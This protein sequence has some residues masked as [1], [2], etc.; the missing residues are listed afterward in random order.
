MRVPYQLKTRRAIDLHSRQFPQSR[1][2]ALVL[3]LS[4]LVLVTFLVMAVFQLVRTD[5]AASASYERGVSTRILSETALNLVIGQ[6]Q[7]ASQRQNEAWVSQPGLIR[8][9]DST[10]QPSRA[11]KL[12]SAARMTVSGEFDPADGGD[13][14]A[15]PS[16]WQG[17]PNEWTDMNE[18]V[19]TTQT[20]S[21]GTLV[22][23]FVYPIVDPRAYNPSSPSDSLVEGFS[24]DTA[25]TS[26][27]DASES[28]AMPVRW[29]YQLQD[30]TLTPGEP[31]GSGGA[32]RIKGMT[33]QNPAIARLAF[34]T[35]DESCKVNI[36]TAGGGVPW[37]TPA[38]ATF[39]IGAS[40]AISDLSTRPASWGENLYEADFAHFQPS[41]DEFQ[42]YP[43]HPATTSLMPILFRPI[44]LALG[45]DPNSA[46]FDQ[47]GTVR[48]AIYQMSPRIQ[49]GS[50]SSLGGTRRGSAPL[51]LA[52]DRLYASLDEFLLSENL[53]A[54]GRR[55]EHTNLGSDGNARRDLV[56]RMRFFLSPFSR[57]PETTLSNKPR[58]VAWPV[59]EN[60]SHDY[61]SSFDRLIAFCGTVGS[62]RYFFT[63][64][65]ALS[66]TDDW[67][68]RNQQIYTYLQGLTGRPIPG[69]GG[70]FLT[71]WDVDR[72]QVLTQIFDY[73]RT[74]N[75]QEFSAVPSWRPYADY[76]Q[77]HPAQRDAI[78][79]VVLPIRP[80]AGPG[81][82][83]TGFGRAHTIT[84]VALILVR[85]NQTNQPGQFRLAIVPEAFSPMAGWSAMA[86]NLRL[87]F[88]N[89][90]TFVINGV[91]VPFTNST[92][93]TFA[94]HVPASAAAPPDEYGPQ[95]GHS[96]LGGYTGPGP[97]FT[98]FTLSSVP[99]SGVFTLPTV[100]SGTNTVTFGSGGQIT[101]DVYSPAQSI[102]GASPQLLQTFDYTLPEVTLPAPRF[103]GTDPA[104]VNKQWDLRR[105]AAVGA[106]PNGLVRGMKDTEASDTV[107]SI[108]PN[109]N[110]TN[111]IQGNNIQGDYRLVAASMA[112]TNMARFFGVSPTTRRAQHS[113]RNGWN[114]SPSQ[115]H[116]G[117][118]VSGMTGYERRPEEG[119][120][121]VTTPDVPEG[122]NGVTLTNGQAGDWDSGPALLGD[123]ALLNKADE[124]SS[125]GQAANRI[126]YIGNPAAVAGT[127]PVEASLFS[128]NRQMPSPVMFGSLPTGVKRNLPWQTL[129]FRPDAA[130][131]NLP[132]GG[133]HPGSQSPPD[134]LLLDNFWV[135][136]VE[137]YA[138]SEPFSTAGKI[139]INYQLAPFS[140]IRRDSS[141]RALLDGALVTAINPTTPTDGRTLIERLKNADDGAPGVSIRKNIDPDATIT[142]FEERFQSNKPFISASEICEIPLVPEGV[143]SSG[144]SLSAIKSSL[145]S[146]W[147]QHKLT[148]DNLLERPYA[149]IYPRVTTKSN[150]Y[151]VHVRVQRIQVSPAGLQVGEFGTGKGAVTGEFRGSFT[152]ERFLEPNSDSFVKDD[153]AGNLVPVSNENDP[154]AILGPYKFRVLSSKQLSL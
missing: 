129:L 49:G 15:S 153:G 151:T 75:L 76:P 100:I 120:S 115:S 113:L 86:V 31:T 61:R 70:D 6:I 109:G 38:G 108:L 62:R 127:V 36:N 111:N 119:N 8:T 54:N 81:A 44:A 52:D 95:L 80:A 71:K 130:W 19:K 79:G 46:T 122:I 26:Q 90:N 66:T 101:F 68:V 137:P 91:P 43:G 57:A 11:Y 146:F 143:A 37:D 51:G 13:L 25:W 55:Q 63:R 39:P 99:V 41:A 22:E 154:D 72:D 4:L 138:I 133:S 64:E 148:G 60:T 117:N 69:F 152:I 16:A 118:L 73:I 93:S 50:G 89:L 34:W 112:N 106:N 40:L 107:F 12:Y 105:A 10:G 48:E 32:V 94:A 42:R 78:R 23:S 85:E 30:G 88:S 65:N 132:G 104:A 110:A 20:D 125:K 33:P 45:I 58:V 98:L 141:V 77:L 14:P 103:D 96:R 21:N 144:A 131:L 150:T 149:H 136:V 124:G 121:I 145:G 87:E 140:Y 28:V 83:T 74:T 97:F 134:H 123:G 67:N 135:P 5:T 47:V 116:Y 18:P 139:N 17:T 56:E 102:A 82:G 2:F 7:E 24:Y 128:P 114:R 3:V 1:G 84:E 147:S 92:H 126:P 142:F 9:Y 53:D 27:T 29:L 35:D 59:H